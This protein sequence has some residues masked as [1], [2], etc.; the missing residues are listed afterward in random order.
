M[1]IGAAIKQLRQLHIARWGRGEWTQAAC[2]GRA[3][4]S[5]GSW[6]D[7]ENDRH[8]PSVDTIRRAAEILE[9][10]VSVLACMTDNAPRTPGDVYDPVSYESMTRT[11]RLAGLRTVYESERKVI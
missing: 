10:S 4:M 2:A 7:L 9:C 1:K 11:M 5:V 3:G 8:S 6:R